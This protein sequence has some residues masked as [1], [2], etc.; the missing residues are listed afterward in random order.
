[1]RIRPNP[2]LFWSVAL[3]LLGVSAVAYAIFPAIAMWMLSVSGGSILVWDIGIGVSGVLAGMLWADCTYQITSCQDQSVAQSLVSSNN[4]GAKK[5]LIADLRP[6]AVRPNPDPVKFNDPVSPA[7]D[8]TPKSTYSLSAAYPQAG[9]IN[10]IGLAS[11]DT[12][13]VLYSVPNAGYA[14]QMTFLTPSNKVYPGSPYSNYASW[15]VP[16][17]NGSLSGTSLTIYYKFQSVQLTCDNGYTLSGSNCVLSTPTAVKKPSTTPCQVLFD[18][19]TKSFQFDAANARCDGLAS[20]FVSSDGKLRVSDNQGASTSVSPRGDGG[21]DVV[22]TKSDGSW[23]GVATAPFDA[24]QGGYPI[25]GTSSGAGPST[26]PDP[27]AGG[28]IG[29]GSPGGSGTGSGTT[30][31]GSGDCSGYGCAKETTQ[32]EVLT[33]VK[34]ITK[35][36]DSATVTGAYDS[37]AKAAQLVSDLQGKYKLASDYNGITSQIAANLGLPP[38]GQCS[39]AVFNWSFLGRPMTVDFAWLCGPIAPIVNWFFWMLVTIAAISEVI[40]ILTGRG[41]P[42]DNVD[43]SVTDDQARDY[44]C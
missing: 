36:A 30:G 4:N 17:G 3:G 40:Y 18:P 42:G 11:L 38:G 8:V 33:S 9:T 43:A 39:N 22:K 25:T 24:N 28:T 19:S 5:P 41:L 20:T 26:N 23:K 14:N 37:D 13:V 7:R 27:G 32:Q 34:D 44:I 12:E 2:F 1:M 29:G 6:A 15:T 10:S 35:A 21:F 31:T 16:A